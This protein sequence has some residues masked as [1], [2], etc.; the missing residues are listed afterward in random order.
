MVNLRRATV[1]THRGRLI[2]VLAAV[3]LALAAVT[4]WRGETARADGATNGFFQFASAGITVTEGGTATITVER[5]GGTQGAPTVTY[6]ILYGAGAN[7]SDL[8][9][10]NPPIG[11]GLSFTA[12]QTSRTINA[13]PGPNVP[14]VDDGVAQGTRTITFHLS[15]VDAGGE[16]GDSVDFVL[17]ILDNDGP[18]VFSFSAADYPVTEGPSGS[19]TV[20]I[21][22]NHSGGA[23][24]VDWNTSDGTAFDG[25]DYTAAGATLLFNGGQA[26]RTFTVTVLNDAVFNP[27]RSFNLTLSNPTGGG[28]ISG[29][30]PATVTITDDDMA[31]TFAYSSANYSV[32]EGQANATLT[33]NRTLGVRGAVD[34]TCTRTGGT[35]TPDGDPD[36]DIGANSDVASFSDGQTSAQCLIPIVADALVEGDETVDFDLTISSDPSGT[37][38]LGAQSTATL[39]IHDAG[40]GT[41]AFSAA[42]YS[43]AE[44]VAGGSITITVN[45]TGSTVGA[46]SVNYAVA[47]GGATPAVDGVDFTAVSATLNFINGQMSATFNLAILDDLAL[48][49][50]KTVSLTLSAPSAGATIGVPGSATLTINDNEVAGPTVTQVSP[51]GGPTAGNHEVT[52][53][54]TNF[55]GVQQVL[56]G[57][58]PGT[59]VDV[60]SPTSLTVRTPAMAAGTVRVRVVTASGTS[61]DTIADDYTFTNGPVVTD[62]TPDNGPTGLVTFVTIKG[63]NLAAATSVTFGGVSATFTPIDDTTISAAAPAS[64]TTGTVDV[65]V[66]SA[67]GTSP[68]S[69]DAKFSYTGAPVTPT[70]TQLDPASIPINTGG[71]QIKV[72]G[73]GFTGT[74]TVTFGGAAGT[75]VVVESTTV[76][77]VT[78]PTCTVAGVLEVVVTA[79]GGSSATAGAANDLTCS[80]N[81]GTLFS[82]LLYFRWTLL[83]WTGIDGIDVLQ[84][85]KGQEVPGPDNPGTNDV[86]GM[87]TA[88]YRWSAGGEGCATGVF[89]CWLG[90]FPAGVGVPGAND[91]ET[92]IYGVAYWVAILGPGPVNWSILSGP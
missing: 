20:T 51:A 44:N 85:L 52:V 61:P 3:A 74:V 67:G 58:T 60:D 14:T 89:A 38:L 5:E 76:L 21:T 80:P 13:V 68:V 26:S 71:K 62:V 86:S 90:F 56:F 70:V 42:T 34:V 40:G 39:T 79:A 63:Q 55:V 73:T 66:T 22:V 41:F 77:R 47:A 84:A 18:P 57:E 23:G 19:K 30:N 36:E 9:W 37:A 7:A 28:S 24:S 65:L 78:A 10:Q 75:G 35:A 43:V 83:V 29:T 11:A 2:L 82:N 81:P 17:T 32:N 45:R 46:A 49:G 88:V 72:T 59:N 25:V 50:P 48:D 69:T 16:L 15:Q 4:G 1:R 12:G 92:L 33:I 91:F 6:Q 64:G 31:G 27:T 8:D 54:G 53:T 87:A